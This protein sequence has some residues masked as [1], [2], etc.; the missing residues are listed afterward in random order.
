M[1]LEYYF[2]IVFFEIL[3]SVLVKQKY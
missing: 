2:L 1:L 3:S